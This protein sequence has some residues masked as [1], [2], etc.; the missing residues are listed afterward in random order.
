[1]K[2]MNIDR[3]MLIYKLDK[4]EKKQRGVIGEQRRDYRESTVIARYSGQVRHKLNLLRS[5]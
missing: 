3:E 2:E 5:Q 4:K 1:M